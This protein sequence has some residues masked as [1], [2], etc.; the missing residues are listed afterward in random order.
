MRE[1]DVDRSGRVLRTRDAGDPS[2]PVVMYFHGTP[3]SRLDEP[4]SWT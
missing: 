4:G 2:G 3:G 1:I